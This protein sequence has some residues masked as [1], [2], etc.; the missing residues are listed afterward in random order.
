MSSS[1]E[2]N[3]CRRLAILGATGSVGRNAVAVA[4][5][6]SN[7]LQTVCVTCSH[8]G[9]ELQTI[10]QELHARY[11][12][13]ASDPS[14]S[15]VGSEDELGELLAGPEVDVVLCAIQGLGAL[16]P[17][18][19]ALRA[20]KTVCL[21]TKEVLVAA[22]EWVM[23]TARQYGGRILPVDSEHCAVFQCLRHEDH[24]AL[25]RLILTCSGGPF[26]RC[27]LEELHAVTPVETEHHPTWSMGPKITLDSATLMNKAFE[28]MEAAWLYGVPESQIEVVIHP[29]SL[30]H[31]M[32]EFV[33]GAILAQLGPTDMR[34]PIQYC[35]TYPNRCPSLM[36]PLDFASPM[37]MEFLPLDARRF[38]AIDLAR[39]ALRMGG[40]A[41]AV[42]NAANDSAC[43]RFREGSLAFDAIVPAI[44]AAL[45]HTPAGKA[46][47]FAALEQAAQIASETVRKY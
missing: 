24:G 16:K 3:P 35:L 37:S 45:E 46:D 18:L 10:A 5:A 38:P 36:R 6:Y 40:L 28:V 12:Y 19:A 34:L 4:Q 26:Y 43:R 30:I 33:D 21:A 15:N 9:K 1:S 17:V 42:L 32:V 47:S 25:R 22:G 8:Q 27:S 7:R 13:C 39:R 2:T 31:S 41:G 14:V 44:A 23:E 29:Q 20:G 11:C